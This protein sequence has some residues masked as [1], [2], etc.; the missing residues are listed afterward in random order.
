M[1]N[2]SKTLKQRKKVKKVV[3]FGPEAIKDRFKYQNQNKISNFSMNLRRLSKQSQE[4]CSLELRSCK[5]FNRHLKLLI[6]FNN[7]II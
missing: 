4:T 5:K 7:Q 1:T 3:S 2:R 6:T